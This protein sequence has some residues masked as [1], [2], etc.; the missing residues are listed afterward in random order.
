MGPCLRGV[1]ARRPSCLPLSSP[2]SVGKGLSSA[3]V[4]RMKSERGGEGLE[5]PG[6]IAPMRPVGGSRDWASRV[7]TPSL[8][9]RSVAGA[10]GVLGVSGGAWVSQCI[11]E[12]LPHP[13]HLRPILVQGYITSFEGFVVVLKCWIETGILEHSAVR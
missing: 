8:P 9:G 3:S 6:P 2:S 13:P 5:G 10:P 12:C 4:S 1:E 7:G 11:S